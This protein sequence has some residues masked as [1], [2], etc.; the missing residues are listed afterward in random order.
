MVHENLRNFHPENFGTTA[1]L[2][3]GTGLLLHQPLLVLLGRYLS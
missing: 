2:F 1:L 3:T